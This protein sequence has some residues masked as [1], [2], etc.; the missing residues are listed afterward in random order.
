[1][2]RGRIA[3]VEGVFWGFVDIPFTAPFVL[4][5]FVS[6]CAFSW[7][8][9]WLKT[10]LNQSQTKNAMRYWVCKNAIL[11]VFD[12]LCFPLAVL[13]IITCWRARQY[14]QDVYEKPHVDEEIDFCQQGDVAELREIAADKALHVSA[15]AAPF[16]LHAPDD[17]LCATL[18]VPDPYHVATVYHFGNLLL[19]VPFIFMFVLINVSCWRRPLLAFLLQDAEAEADG[20]LSDF[21]RR[22]L[23]AVHCCLLFSDIPAVMFLIVLSVTWRSCYVWSLLSRH[24]LPKMHRIIFG[25]ALELLFDIREFDC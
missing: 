17:N 21:S 15:A 18:F 5:A 14:T 12:L 10:K 20:K 11:G 2:M 22:K 4:L 25:Q 23:I 9:S 3:L 7:R 1:M 13:V 19:D 6:C 8:L 16:Q 24:G